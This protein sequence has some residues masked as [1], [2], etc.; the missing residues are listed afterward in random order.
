MMARERAAKGRIAMR[1]FV[2]A[3][4][5]AALLSGCVSTLDGVWESEAR[6]NCQQEQG[7]TRQSDCQD[8]V[9]A[10]VRERR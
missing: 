2:L 3:M 7:A 10:E 6:K 9:D 5:A 1:K 8:R 4:T